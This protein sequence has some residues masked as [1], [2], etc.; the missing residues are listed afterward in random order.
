MELKDFV[1]NMR[2]HFDK[3]ASLEIILDKIIKRLPK[4]NNDRMD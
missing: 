4:E 1:E 2:A 3:N